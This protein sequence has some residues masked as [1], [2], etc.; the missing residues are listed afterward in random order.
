M[1]AGLARDI[2]R[3]GVAAG[4]AQGINGTIATGVAAA[5]SSATDATALTA[6]VNTVTSG[7]AGTGVKLPSMQNGDEV[8]VANEVQ[9]NGIILYPDQTTVSLG[10]LAVNA[11]LVIPP[12]CAIRVVKTSSTHAVVFMGI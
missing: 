8:I 3:G 1:G 6:S 11:G 4:T 7:A 5:G 12:Q 2:M 10:Q 9:A